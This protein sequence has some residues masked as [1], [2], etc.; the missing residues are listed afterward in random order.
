M[1]TR[2]TGKLDMNH[3]VDF[4]LAKSQVLEENSEWRVQGFHGPLFLAGTAEAQDSF[5]GGSVGL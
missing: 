4:N 3:R 5:G 1:V 2:A